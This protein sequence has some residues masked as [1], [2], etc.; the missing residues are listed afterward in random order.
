LTDEESLSVPHIGEGLGQALL[1]PA[2]PGPVLEVVDIGFYS[3]HHV[4]RI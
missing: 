1:F 4:H 3:P 2:K